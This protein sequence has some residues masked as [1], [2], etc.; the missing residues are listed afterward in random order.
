[1]I[2][3]GLVPASIDGQLYSKT[4]FEGFVSISNVE[5]DA[6]WFPYDSY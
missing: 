1:M 4:I 5:K 3:F 6:M 2:D